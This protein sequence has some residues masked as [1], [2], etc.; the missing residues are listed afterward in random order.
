MLPTVD[1]FVQ[2]PIDF[3][4]LLAASDLVE[5]GEYSVRI[6]STRHLIEMKKRAGRRHDLD[7][8]RALQRLQEKP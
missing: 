8:I 5:L 7:G 3:E 6:A 2:Y 4:E 1:L